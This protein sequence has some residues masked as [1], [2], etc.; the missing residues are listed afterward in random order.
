[1]LTSAL[2]ICELREEDLWL[3]FIFRT[4]DLVSFISGSKSLQPE[5]RKKGI[6]PNI[7]Q[8]K[9]R[10]NTIFMALVFFSIKKSKRKRIMRLLKNMRN[11]CLNCY[12]VETA[13]LNINLSVLQEL[14]DFIRR[15]AD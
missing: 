14:G 12:S 15:R 2:E 3:K 6:N 13:M 5:K 8:S 1:M 11:A 7:K 10:L 4:T 9:L